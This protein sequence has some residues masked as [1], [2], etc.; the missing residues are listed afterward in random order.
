MCHSKK[1]VGIG[2][3]IGEFRTGLFVESVRFELR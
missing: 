2:S 3:P 1:E